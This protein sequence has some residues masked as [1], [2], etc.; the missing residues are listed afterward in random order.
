M[1]T[2]GFKPNVIKSDGYISK[3]VKHYSDIEI[4]FEGIFVGCL[5]S[6]INKE[7]I[8]LEAVLKYLNDI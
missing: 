6:T 3:A 8:L 5:G 2:V 1:Y 4:D 7:G